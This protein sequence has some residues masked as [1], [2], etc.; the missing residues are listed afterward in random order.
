VKIDISD[1]HYINR[2]LYSMK[3]QSNLMKVLCQIEYFFNKFQ[4]EEAPANGK[5]QINYPKYLS[6]FSL[7]KLQFI[8]Y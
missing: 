2:E 4:K 6:K 5:V 1:Y 3:T 7:Y 8:D